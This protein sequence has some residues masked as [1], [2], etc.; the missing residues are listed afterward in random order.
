MKKIEKWLKENGIDYS[1]ERYGNSTYF[2]DDFSVPG[3]SIPFYFDGIGNAWEDQ[4]A[5]TKYMDN[6]RA[7]MCKCSKFGAGISYYIMTVFD[8]ARLAEHE[9]KIRKSVQKFWE[10]KRAQQM[11]ESA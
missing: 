1:V 9:E 3:L 6:N 2:D 11:Q 5:L 8:A 7:Y 4:K 10:E